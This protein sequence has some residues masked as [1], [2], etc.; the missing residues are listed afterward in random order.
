VNPTSFAYVLRELVKPFAFFLIVLT[1]V[2]WLTQSLRVVDTVVNSGQGA[3][4]FLQFVGLLLPK[5]LGIVLPLAAF[6]ATLYAINKL[7]VD[8]EI[9]AL[10][11]AGMSPARLALPVA[12]FGAAV[13]VAVA[14]CTLYLSPSAMREMRDRVHDM[15]ADIANALIF[16]GQFLH[17]SSGL[18]I[19]VRENDAGRMAGVFVHDRRDPEAEVTYTADEALLTNGPEGPRLVMAQGAAQRRDADSGALTLLQFDE[20]VFDLSQFMTQDA[21]RGLK[22][23]ERPTM[24]LI[25]PTAEVLAEAAEG[26]LLAEGHDRIS[27]PLYALAL[28]LVGLAAV[29]SRGFTR[30]G[31]GQRIGAAI[32]AG[33]GLRLLGFAAKSAVTAAPALW[34]TLY[35]PP[36]LGVAAAMLALYGAGAAGFRRAAA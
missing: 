35:A 24:E 1:G 13:T 20:L 16:E 23:S 32:V 29:L 5:V 25:A 31:Y 28:P 21:E 4:L 19:Y 15:R 36:I 26:R 34:P 33:V 3:G 18:T 7:F 30:R 9:V 12:T 11:A 8:S 27:M 10:I 6:G 22:T 14:V 17:P 2:I